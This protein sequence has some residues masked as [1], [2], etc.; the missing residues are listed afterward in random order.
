MEEELLTRA[1]EILTKCQDFKTK[2]NGLIERI[3]AASSPD[4]LCRQMRA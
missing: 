4:S 1:L 3:L 2:I